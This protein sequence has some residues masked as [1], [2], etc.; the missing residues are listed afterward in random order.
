MN[1]HISGQ[2][3]KKDT[4]SQFGILGGLVEHLKHMILVF[5]Q[6]Y[7]YFHHVFQKNIN[8]VTQ[9]SLLNKPLIFGEWNYGSKLPLVSHKGHTSSQNNFFLIIKSE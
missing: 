2:K 5:K 4:A 8:I 9:T 3:A 6:H 7:T 1:Y